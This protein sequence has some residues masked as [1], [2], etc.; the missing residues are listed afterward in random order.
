[1]KKWIYL[2]KAEF[3]IIRH[4]Q[5]SAQHRFRETMPIVFSIV[6]F[7]LFGFVLKPVWSIYMFLNIVLADS[8]WKSFFK[9]S[10]SRNHA[11]RVLHSR[12]PPFGFVLKPVVSMDH[13]LAELW[14]NRV[15]NLGLVSETSI[16]RNLAY[17]VLHSRFPPFGFVLKPFGSIEYVSDELWRNRFRWFGFVT[18][19]PVGFPTRLDLTGTRELTRLPGW[20]S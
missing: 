11:Y 1:M 16:S 20:P 6:D 13:V 10:I 12:F 7:P 8:C 9:T 5:N 3:L 4:P 19:H 15:W 14:R 2:S 18:F 17:R